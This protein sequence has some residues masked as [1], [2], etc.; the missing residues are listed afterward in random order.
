MTVRPKYHWQ[1]N[2]RQGT[3]TI[4]TVNSVQSRLSEAAF[5]GHGRIG[6]AIH[7]L[8]KDSHVNLG[9]EVG[10]FGTSNFTVAFGMRN[11]S[12]HGD[13]ELDIIG[14]QVMQGHGNFFSVRLSDRRIFFH[15][16]ENS[17]AKHYV[18]VATK[19]LSMMP[20]RTWFHVA[21][22]RQGRTIK[23]YIDGVLAAE[24]ESKTG[25]ANINN[26]VDVKLGHSR[27]GTPNAQ[28][29]DLRIYYTA[30][31]DAEIQ[32]LVPPANPPLRDGEIELVGADNAAVI[33][34]QNVED[35]SRFSSSFKQLRV[36]HNTGVTLYQQNNFRGTAQK[37]YADLPDIRLSRL[38][39][40]PKSIRIWP[41][42][43]EPFTGKWVIKAP[44]GQFLS[45][46]KSVL[47]TSPRRSFHELFRFHYNLQRNQLQLIPGSDQESTLLKVSPGEDPTHLFVDDLEHLKDEFS[48]INQAN[49]QW[50]ALVEDNTFDWT[51]QKEDRAIFIRVAKMAD[52][53][54]Q[55]GELA[56]GE[57]ALYKH[58]AYYG[59]TWILSDTDKYT[60]G[61]YTHLKDFHDLN[62]QTSSI[63]LGPDTGVTVFKNLDHQAA[64]DKREEEIED[65]VENVPRLSDR[66][67]GNDTISSIQI[68]RTIAPED[69]FTSYTTKLSQDY[70]M[71]GDN[72]EEFSSYRTTLRFEPGAG[73]IEIAATDLTQIEVDGT[74]YDIDEERSV[75]LSPNQL[76]QIMITSEA[77]GLNTPGLKIR[78]S[79]MASNERVVIFPNREAHKQI[80]EL[81]DGALW[82]AKDA[83]G[84]FI[85]DRKAHSKAEVASA[86]NTIKRVMATV[87][88]GE[89]TPTG[90]NRVQSA[91]RAVSGTTIDKP[92]ELTLGA[93]GSAKPA[94]P[95]D[96]RRSVI[97]KPLIAERQV[98]SDEWQKLL[99]QATPAEEEDSPEA[100][101]P[102]TLGT[103][104]V[105]SARRFGRRLGRKFKKAIK[106]ATSVVIGKIKDI[107]HVIVKTA[108]G[109]IDFV[110]D[111]A[112]KVADFVEGV[113]E[114]VVKSIK[115]FIEFL[116][117]LFNW[118]DILE[119]HRLLVKTINSALDSAS[120][121]VASAKG[122]VSAFVDD[123]QDGLNK[124]ANDLI[125]A[126]GVEPDEVD[127]GSS[128]DLPEAAEWLLNKI[129]GGSK[130]SDSKTTPE[131]D[132]AEKDRTA[133]SAMQQ[134]F[135][136]FL[137]AL[138]T[139]VNIKLE[140]FDGL[141]GTVE[142]IIANPN[143]PEL[144]L[145]TVIDTFRDVGIGTLD[146]G[147]DIIF[148]F[149]DIVVAAIELFQDL[150]NAEIR[151]PLVSALF[152]MLGAGKLT[153]LNLT[154][155]L[156]SIPATVMTK[157]MFGKVSLGDVP[158]PEF[159]TKQIVASDQ[160][161]LSVQS[162][163]DGIDIENTIL[164]MQAFGGI[165]IAADVVNAFISTKMDL[166]PEG[167][168]EGPIFFE[169]MSLF[170]S[171]VSWL[172]S[173]PSS[174]VEPGGYP[175][176]IG[177]KKHNVSKSKKEEEEMYWERVLW[178]WRT[179]MLGIDIV[180]VIGA[181]G[182]QASGIDKDKF[183]RQRLRR[184]T[185]LLDKTAPIIELSTVLAW[186]EL[187]LAGKYLSTVKED[188][189]RTIANEVL[190]MLPGSFAFL[191]AI[192]SPKF[193]FAALSAMFI[194]NLV[195]GVSTTI[196]NI[197]FLQNDVAE[198]K[199]Q[200]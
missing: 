27:R 74:T 168:E 150:L 189:K 59:R 177:Q 200:L 149:L 142:T 127:K 194:I 46:A 52:N 91:N 126:L 160:Q 148:I 184:A 165:A 113:V 172:G 45:L 8:S 21:V 197:Q 129:L 51:G 3:T 106:K 196:F 97:A 109:I 180:Y 100:N 1:F 61:K 2:E 75:S 186:V 39:N 77:N 173:F 128:F 4:D 38:E 192:K 185:R 134:A 183:P 48:I 146:L 176:A 57:V 122:H 33:L 117:F 130:R 69:V 80:A 169:Y 53:E 90:K 36:G 102:V 144:A 157:L 17:K 54:G 166:I 88:Y 93:T 58:R 40:F 145:A 22:V 34:T 49:N 13:N 35:L 81:E 143:R 154:S 71:V 152:K 151:I 199:Q 23:I 112:E 62:D 155:L 82:N 76:N 182:A 63:R 85:V 66:Q 24:A 94:R 83:K 30:L 133:L 103:A 136:S 162:N 140:M 87:N 65:I 118:D 29:E 108:E 98:S 137:E 116:Q 153:I 96:G 114:T 16:D 95:G 70:R 147:E 161:L 111:T 72:L 47:T 7:L 115:Q 32:A 163:E 181:I 158:E 78:T 104:R 11:I 43:E 123:L 31:S 67:I 12:T 19:R 175:Y 20:N 105:F 68:F 5:K 125:R 107:V 191:R 73:E 131:E 141:I 188:K 64:D 187:G 18:K 124:G 37:C 119:T 193:E 110:V 26:N 167:G 135:E 55:V 50:L 132:L 92:W 120:G 15:V 86:Q 14:D 99:T 164:K 179:A 28:Y 171:G 156:V 101:G 159:S 6:N 89:D 44:K 190:G 121:L 138:K 60:S 170:L 195:S 10:Q 174:K 25:V 41:A 56:P 9:K 79:D 178:G 84:N 42:I 139:A 198:L